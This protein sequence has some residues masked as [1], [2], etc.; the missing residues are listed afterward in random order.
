MRIATLIATTAAVTTAA[1]VGSLA[2]RP[3]VQS[4]WYP[5]LRTPP[6]QPPQRVFPVVWPML[7]ADIA[8]VS[9]STVNGLRDHGDIRAV[10][11]Y[12]GAL[13]VNLVLNGGWSWLFFNRHQLGA[14]AAAAAA[15][16]VSSADLAPR[17]VA[18][19]G[20][21]A[22]RWWLIPSGVP[23]PPCCPPTSGCSTVDAG[24]SGDDT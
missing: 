9:A 14:S 17:A 1:G 19:R 20:C 3:S 12:L 15:L 11:T 2:S 7:Y 23:S 6:Y 5:R 16:T 8:V 21:A 4:E 10:P 22:H 18:A 13:G 24:S